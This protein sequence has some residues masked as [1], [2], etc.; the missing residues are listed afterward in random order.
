MKNLFD[1]VKSGNLGDL[2]KTVSSALG[3][4]NKLAH[5]G[6]AQVSDLMKNMNMGGLLGAAGVG[7]ILG[8]LMGGK[9]AKKMAKGALKVGGTAAV[10][11]LAWQFYQ[12][13]SQ[14]QS[15]PPQ[16]QQNTHYPQTHG[17]TQEQYTTQQHPQPAIQQNTTQE[18]TQQ[19]STALILLEAMV[20]AARA[21]G[22]I[23]AEEQQNIHNAVEALFP[24]QNMSAFLD[25]LLQ[26]PIDPNALAAKVHSKEEA[27]DLYRLSC[28]IITIDSFMERSYLDGLAKALQLQEIEKMNL[29]KEALAAQGA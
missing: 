13:W 20:F 12:K 22:H 23:D 19:D 28:A 6:G 2:G 15:T 21:D 17:H 14:S 8:A 29:E 9:K 3:S 24:G 1:Q 4:G 27:Y 25:T 26:K 7:G 5:S 18:F 16:Q 10:G 11:M